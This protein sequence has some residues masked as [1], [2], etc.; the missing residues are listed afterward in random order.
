MG[1]DTYETI[2]LQPQSPIIMPVV[3]ANWPPERHFNGN[4]YRAVPES[5]GSRNRH[6][7][8]STFG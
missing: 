2:P 4:A 8:W 6:R 3:E 7:P 5:S 1:D